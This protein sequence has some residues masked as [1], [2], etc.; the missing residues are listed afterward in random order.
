MFCEIFKIMRRF[1]IIVVL[2]VDFLN[3]QKYE[4]RDFTRIAGYGIAGY[5]TNGTK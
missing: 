1:V 4:K 3:G 2:K 5:G